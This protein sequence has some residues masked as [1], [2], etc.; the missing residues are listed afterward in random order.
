[1]KFRICGHPAG[2]VVTLSRCLRFPVRAT[3]LLYVVVDSTAPQNSVPLLPTDGGDFV[4]I[5]KKSLAEEFNDPH[6]VII[7][8][9]YFIIFCIFIQFDVIYN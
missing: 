2:S 8:V 5:Q 9:L 3:S 6:H 4:A 7:A 1:V